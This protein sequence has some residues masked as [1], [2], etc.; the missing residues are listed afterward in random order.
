MPNLDNLE[1]LWDNAFFPDKIS[2]DEKIILVLRETSIIIGVKFIN[3]FLAFLLLLTLR[4]FLVNL[5]YKS[6]LN[7]FDLLIY[8]LNLF[9]IT[10]F[11]LS[12]HNYYLSLGIVTSKRVIDV[13][14]LGLF[15][16]EVN[17]ISLGNVQDYN[18]KQGGILAT[19]FGFGDI[20]IRPSSDQDPKDTKDQSSGFVFDNVSNP[21]E[22]VKIID[23][24]LQN[25]QDDN[26]D[27]T[28][29]VNADFLKQALENKL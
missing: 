14:Q 4:I 24:A 20:I 29:K 13:D 6:T 9:F 8:G 17:E 10:L 27:E 21:A 16:R 18:Y 12:F 11:T 7:A 23:I 3:F 1:S 22:F 15:H 2:E 19:L 25:F 28:A 26:R 5:P